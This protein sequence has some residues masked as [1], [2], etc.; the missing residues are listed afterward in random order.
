[1][2]PELHKWGVDIEI[3]KRYWHF[4]MDVVN[5]MINKY[6]CKNNFM[7]CTDL[8]RQADSFFNR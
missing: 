6:D 2:S 4:F 8:P 1:M 3:I 5:Q 7:L